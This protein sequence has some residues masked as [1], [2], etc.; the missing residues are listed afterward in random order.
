M[1]N[2]V[3]M[4]ALVL[5]DYQ[6]GRFTQQEIA[7]PVAGEG[8]VLVRIEA[9]GV[10]PIDYKIRTGRAPYADPVLPAVLGT[11]L[12]GVVEAVGAGV[13]RFKVGDEVYGLV[14]GVR[15]LQGT[16]AEFAAVDWRLLALKPKNL[17]MREAAALPLVFLTAWEGLVDS[18]RLHAG[19]TV[20]VTGGSGGV[21]HIAVQIAKAFGAEVF[22]TASP[23][24][25]EM[26]RGLGATP[27]DYH[28]TKAAD[29]VAAFT[30]GKGFDVVYDTVGGSSLDDALES[31]RIRG[32]VVSCAAFG[33]HSLAPSSLRAATVNGVFVLLPMLTG[34]GRAHHGEV[35]A[36]ATRLV[37]AGKLKPIL[38]P[39]RF[40]LATAHDAHDAVEQGT[41]FGKIVI[42]IAE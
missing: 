25:H 15:G 6:S 3:T 4:R 31:V 2:P 41:A 22:A 12:A 40:T 23:A 10:N 18:A 11:E 37:E 28:T 35:L 29:Y 8:Q 5:E 24:K 30:G 13:S 32:H 42:D 26:V 9:S 19:Q 36:D 38:D 1:S 7:R 20:L 33:T 21:G 16:L 34:E 14:G 17:N 27:I 39:R